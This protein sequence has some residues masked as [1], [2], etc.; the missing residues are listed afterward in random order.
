MHLSSRGRGQTV[1]VLSHVVGKEWVNWYSFYVERRGCACGIWSKLDRIWAADK[2][3]LYYKIGSTILIWRLTCDFTQT[4]PTVLRKLDLRSEADGNITGASLKYNVQR[5][6][7]DLVVAGTSSCIECSAG[8]YSIL[9]NARI[10]APHK[11]CAAITSFYQR[12]KPGRKRL[13]ITTL[14]YLKIW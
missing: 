12:I 8:R 9:G 11:P 3:T 13:K 7:I 6:W 1:Y 2:W 14:F 5:S 10:S 4:R